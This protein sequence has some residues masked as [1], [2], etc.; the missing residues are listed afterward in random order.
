[1]RVDSTILAGAGE[2]FAM[3]AGGIVFA[4]LADVAGGEAPGGAGDDCGGGL[5]AGL[6]GACGVLDLGAAL[7]EDG[8]VDERVG[9]VEAYADDVNLW[10]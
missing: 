7:G 8:E 6:E 3:E 10:G 1:L 4:E 2:G 9:G 5:A